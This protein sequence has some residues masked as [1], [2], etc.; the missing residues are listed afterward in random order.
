MR[1]FMLYG[2]FFGFSIVFIG[3]LLCQRELNHSLRDAMIG[4]LIMAFAARLVFRAVEQ[5]VVEV[6]ER[7]TKEQ[8]QEEDGVR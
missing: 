1:R 3:G 7:E 6:L 2:G 5:C 8:E 4:C